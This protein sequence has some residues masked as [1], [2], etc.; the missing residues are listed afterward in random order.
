MVAELYRRAGVD[1]WADQSR[2]RR[3][4]IEEGGGAEIVAVEE[5]QIE[6]EIGHRVAVAFGQRPLE[7][8]EGGDAARVLHHYLAVDDGVHTR[9]FLKRLGQSAITRRPVVPVAGDQPDASAIEEHQGPVAVVFDLV[10]PTWRPG[11][12]IGAGGELRAPAR[13]HG[14]RHRAGDLG[15]RLAAHRLSWHRRF[16]IDR[17]ASDD[18]VGLLN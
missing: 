11:R 4:A 1:Q 9:E 2:Q 12:R 7:Q 14:G 13:R 18:A 10:D 16:F 3:L 6:G 8:V 17:P 15:R 5:R